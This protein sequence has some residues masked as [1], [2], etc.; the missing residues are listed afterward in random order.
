M[1]HKSSPVRPH[2][3]LGSQRDRSISPAR[4]TTMTAYL[5]SMLLLL[6]S[7]VIR[8][9][10]QQNSKVSSPPRMCLTIFGT[11]SLRYVNWCSYSKRPS[12]IRCSYQQIE[13]ERARR[14]TRVQMMFDE[15]E[16]VWARLS[17]P[18]NYADEFAMAHTGVSDAT[19]QAVCPVSPFSLL[20]V[21]DHP[22]DVHTVRARISGHAGK[23]ASAPSTVYSN[24]KR[25]NYQNVG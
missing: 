25:A 22:C 4:K 24:G 13:P 20:H 8:T 21:N 23:A 5:R 11:G 17:M 3:L 18:E 14:E 9:R 1:K 12:S 7:R 15:L 6:P 19:L 2:P 10:K 16:L